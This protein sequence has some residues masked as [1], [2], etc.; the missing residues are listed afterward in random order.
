MATYLK[1]KNGDGSTAILAQVRVRPFKP[2]ARSFPDKAAAKAWAEPLEAELIERRTRRD[3]RTFTPKAAVRVDLSAL[4]VGGLIVEFLADPETAALRYFDD[5]HR[6]CCWWSQAYGSRRVLAFDVLT[7]REARESLSKGRGPATVNRYLSAMRSCWNW[8]RASGLIPRD[9]LWPER[10]MLT[11]PKGRARFLSD[12]ELASVLTKAREHSALMLAAITV[13]IA[14]GLRQG[15]LLRLDWSDVDF[16]AATLAVR[17]S[18]NDEPRTVH[19]PASAAENLR[20]VKGAKVRAI[21]GPVFTTDDGARLKKSTLEARWKLVRKW[22]GLE[23]FHWHDLRHSCASYMAQAGANLL[24][25]G[26]QLGHK[27]ASVTLRYAH[28]V[29]GAALPSHAALDKKLRG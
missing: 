27:S 17:V 23:N 19:L 10:V 26:A 8:G 7:I 1:R 14:T 28:L 18:K 4:T 20:A 16:S 25:I 21:A 5:L 24:E 29:Q 3:D 13:S 9:Q 15:E 6:L 22:A 11:E 2:T 12:A